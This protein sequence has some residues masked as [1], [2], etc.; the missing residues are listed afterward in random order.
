M[1]NISLSKLLSSG[2]FGQFM[3]ECGTVLTVC[4]HNGY[5]TRL[6]DMTIVWRE[7]GTIDHIKP[8][9]T[10]ALRG[11]R[12]VRRVPNLRRAAIGAEYWTKGGFRARIESRRGGYWSAALMRTDG[13]WHSTM[14]YDRHGQPTTMPDGSAFDLV[15]SH[16]EVDMDHY[17]T[18]PT[19]SDPQHKVSDSKHGT[20]A[21]L[22]HL[23]SNGGLRGH[24][25][26]DLFP[27]VP[28]YKGASCE[29][30]VRC[31][32]GREEGPFLS[33]HAMEKFVEVDAAIKEHDALP[34]FSAPVLQCIGYE[35]SQIT[36]TPD[37]A[38]LVREAMLYIGVPTD[39]IDCI[40]I[41]DDDCNF[42]TLAEYIDISEKANKLLD[43]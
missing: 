20:A 16:A 21:T 5:R 9:G 27:Y 3:T 28:F 39:D 32:D 42:H 2:E 17:P 7:S 18:P 4:R 19:H 14:E 1:N 33:I 26:G 34:T 36:L 10:P 37:T 41:I 38:E 15:W 13:S 6:G 11:T 31:P 43:N 25:V 40:G 30:W 22:G 29:Q 12:L 8:H 35:A 23:S 24:S